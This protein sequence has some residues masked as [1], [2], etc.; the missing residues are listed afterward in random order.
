MDFLGRPT[1]DSLPGLAYAISLIR[2]RPIATTTAAAALYLLLV[3]ALRF[4]R[5]NQI[6]RDYGYPKRPLASMTVDEAYKIHRK[7]GKLEFPETFK[8]SLFFALFK[9]RSLSLL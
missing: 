5:R 4:R 9:V 1:I 7:L 3:R 2:D 8:T 6:V